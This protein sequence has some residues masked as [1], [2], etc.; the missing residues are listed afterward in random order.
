MLSEKE[1]PF[2]CAPKRSISFAIF[3]MGSTVHF[4]S[5]LKLRDSVSFETSSN[6]PFRWKH[7]ARV[8]LPARSTALPTSPCAKA[9]PHKTDCN[10]TREKPCIRRRHIL[11]MAGSLSLSSV[12]C[13][14][15]H[16]LPL[17]KIC[18][19]IHGVSYPASAV[20]ACTSGECSIRCLKNVSN[21]ALSWMLPGVTSASIRACRKWYAPRTTFRR[22]CPA[23]DVLTTMRRRKTSW[24]P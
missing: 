2:Q 9:L 23:P 3:F 11:A 18:L 1:Q 13:R 17:S 20:T 16:A 8:F 22:R 15:G 21:A 5:P 10:L 19:Q 6:V 12:V 24:A 7:K 14:A 4:I